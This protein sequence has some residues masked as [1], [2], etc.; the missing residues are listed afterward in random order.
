VVRQGSAEYV[1]F[2]IAV[3]DLEYGAVRL[4]GNLIGSAFN[5]LAIGKPVEATWEGLDGIE[6]MPRWRLASMDGNKGG[7]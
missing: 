3:I 7:R 2:V 4:I 5:E 1:P 6:A